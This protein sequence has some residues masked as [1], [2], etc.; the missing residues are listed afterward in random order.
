MVAVGRD[1]RAGMVA[2]LNIG[3]LAVVAKEMT[4]VGRATLNWGRVTAF[5]EKVAG[6]ER[7]SGEARCEMDMNGVAPA[8]MVMGAGG[9]F[10]RP[11]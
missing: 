1:P 10:G 3:T 6:G 8:C 9:S 7:L 2:A 5:G 11:I 4:G